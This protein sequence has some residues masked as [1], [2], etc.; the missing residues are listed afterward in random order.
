MIYMEAWKLS[1]TSRST[2]FSSISHRA[3]VRPQ[4]SYV[5]GYKNIDVGGGLDGWRKTGE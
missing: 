3:E 1:D 5:E 4:H 2:L